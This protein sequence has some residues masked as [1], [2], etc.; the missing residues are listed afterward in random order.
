MPKNKPNGK[1]RNWAKIISWNPIC[2]ITKRL[3]TESPS[4][5][6]STKMQF[7][8][9]N[10][11]KEKEMDLASW[12]TGNPDCTKGSGARISGRAKAMNGTLMGIRMKEILKGERQ[13]EKECINGQ[14]EKFTKG[15][16]KTV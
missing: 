14:M 15:N 10:C 2:S 12:S 6:R 13:T 4:V 8:E 1:Y 11:L 5:S 9:D 16:G 3:E 7:T